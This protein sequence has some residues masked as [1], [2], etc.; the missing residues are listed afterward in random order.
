MVYQPYTPNAKP[1]DPSY[2]QGQQSGN[3]Q[4]QVQQ[5]QSAMPG[6]ANGAQVPYSQVLPDYQRSA[7]EALDQSAIPPHL[8]N[9]VRDYFSQLEPQR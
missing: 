3:G 2:V 6:V 1:G 9:Y 4:T 5:G 7:G 8:K